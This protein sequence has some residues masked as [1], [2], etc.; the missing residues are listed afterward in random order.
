[1]RAKE[2]EREREREGE[3]E[4]LER[5]RCIINFSTFIFLPQKRKVRKRNINFEKNELRLFTN[6]LSAISLLPYTPEGC[7]SFN[8]TINSRV[9]M[10]FFAQVAKN[11]HCVTVRRILFTICLAR[12]LFT[13]IVFLHSKKIVL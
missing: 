7:S 8:L 1:V 13:K 2:R 6:S 3:R 9:A 5:E 4:G 10:F 11:K 12:V